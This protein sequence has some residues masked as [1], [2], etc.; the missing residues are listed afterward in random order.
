MDFLSR[1]PKLKDCSPVGME[2]VFMIFAWRAVWLVFLMLPFYCSKG[3]IYWIQ[4]CC[5]KFIVVDFILSSC[6]RNS[7]NQ[8]T[9][10]KQ[11]SRKEN[12][13]PEKKFHFVSI[14]ESICPLNFLSIMKA[15]QGGKI[16]N[17]YQFL[18]SNMKIFKLSHVTVTLVA[19][20]IRYRVLP[21]LNNI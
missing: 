2:E 7:F 9:T 4:N 14:L 6:C 19:S 13:F 3:G 12:K 5:L 10:S 8:W 11:T 16:W 21:C 15:I 1:N 18:F 17:H 20:Q